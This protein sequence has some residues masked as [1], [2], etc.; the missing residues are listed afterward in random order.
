MKIDQKPT[1][2]VLVT[3]ELTEVEARALSAIA[4]YAHEGVVRALYEN[5]GT[6]YIKSHEAG[7]LSLLAAVKTELDPILRRTNQARKAFEA[8]P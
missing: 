4:S 8:T 7:L 3:I 2:A 1:V 6:T 5:L